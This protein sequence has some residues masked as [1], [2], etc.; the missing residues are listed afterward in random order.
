[1]SIK[2]G[3]E[4]IIL[5]LPEKQVEWLRKMSKKAD[6]T[7]SKF[8]SIFLARKADELYNFLKFQETKPTDEELEE[9]LKVIKTKWLDD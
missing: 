1:M 8:I 6:K 5:T 4:R 2:K 9:L 7:P 3:K